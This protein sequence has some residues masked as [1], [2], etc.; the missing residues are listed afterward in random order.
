MNT[1]FCSN[2]PS[3]RGKVNNQIA[4]GDKVVMRF[5]SKGTREGEFIGIAPTGKQVSWTGITIDRIED[6]KIVESWAD[7]DLLGLLPS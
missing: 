2:T 3:K 7:W 5:T 6:G 1:S 4:E